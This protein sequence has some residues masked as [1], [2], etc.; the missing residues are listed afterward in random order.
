MSIKIT[1]KFA[2]SKPKVSFTFLRT[3][4][5]CKNKVTNNAKLIQTNILLKNETFFH[6]LIKKTEGIKYKY[7]LRK[8]IKETWGIRNKHLKNIKHLNTINNW[9]N[10]IVFLDTIPKELKIYKNQLESNDSIV[11]RSFF[12][13]QKIDRPISDIY[14]DMSV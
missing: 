5:I 2:E 10:Y 1:V 11:W 9:H 8:H 13:I 7:E 12:E 6:F 14:L 3:L 4:I